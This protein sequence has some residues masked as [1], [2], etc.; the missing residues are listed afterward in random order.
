[1]FVGNT[2]PGRK[3]D[4]PVQFRPADFETLRSFDINVTFAKTSQQLHQVPG[5]GVVVVEKQYSGIPVNFH[6]YSNCTVVFINRSEIA[7]KINDFAT[8]AHPFLFAIGFEGEKGF[9]VTH[10]EAAQ[11]GILYDF[12]GNTNADRSRQTPG[13]RIMPVGFGVYDDAFRKVMFH[14]KRGDTYLINLT[15]PTPVASDADPVQLFRISRAPFKLYVPGQFLVFS[16]ELFVRICD[17]MISSCPMKGTRNAALPGAAESLLS[18]AKELYEHNTIVDLIRNDLAMVS[19]HVRVEKF[20][21]L[22]LIRTNRGDLWQ[23]SSLISGRLPEG[24][25]GHLGEIILSLLP[26][27]S[28]TGAPKER[29]VQIIRDAEPYERGFYTG[30]F[31]FFDGRKLTTAVAIRFIELNPENCAPVIRSFWDMT[32][33]ESFIENE[34][35]YL[36]KSGG[37]ITALSNAG[38]EYREMISKVYIPVD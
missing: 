34:W 12:E 21:Y 24:Y 30:I 14:L 7:R 23:M 36:F 25:A 26:A 6:V 16:P 11:Q 32:D 33:S 1:M 20:R 18:D 37:G 4:L 5:E 17:G 13:F 8:R 27:G 10:E 19:T 2:R 38:D 31:G 9:V 29:T 28:V 22:E 35:K 3:N 15:F